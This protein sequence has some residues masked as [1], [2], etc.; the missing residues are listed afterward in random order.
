MGLLAPNKRYESKRER[1]LKSVLL[2]EMCFSSEMLTVQK[3]FIFPH[4]CQALKFPILVLSRN[5]IIIHIFPKG[6]HFWKRAHDFVYSTGQNTRNF[7]S[8]SFHASL[9]R[10]G[11]MQPAY[12][13]MASPHYNDTFIR[14]LNL[15]KNPHPLTMQSEKGEQFHKHVLAGYMTKLNGN[16]PISYLL[17]IW[18]KLKAVQMLVFPQ[19]E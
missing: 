11:E 2:R 4:Q 9:L 16:T 3:D 17:T 8:L 13:D 12:T 6:Q 5:Q 15:S 10:K 7:L 1:T 14:K 19:R 18:Y